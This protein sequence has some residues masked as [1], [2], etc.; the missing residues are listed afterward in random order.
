MAINVLGNGL[1]EA[2]QHADALTV[3]EVE[4][5]MLRRVGGPD[6]QI[7]VTQGNLA[8]TYAI[9]GRY[10]HAS[11]MQREVYSGRLKLL[12]EAHE[13]TLIAA[14]NYASSLIELRRFKEARSLLRKMM[15][16]AR[17][18]LGEGNQCTLNM[19]Q[20][21]AMAL[22][23]DDGATPDDLRE[24]VTRL[25]D[26]ARTAQRVLGRA[27][28]FVANIEAGLREARAAL[29]AREAPPGRSS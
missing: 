8:G 3:G 5:S 21:Y 15:P 13:E 17:R 1:S 14:N 9:L 26:T 20:V 19:R 4:L 2:D 7:L 10:E 29:R 24:A 23:R 16:V 22:Y 28:P 27:H 6:V 12:G 11:R 25:E 18:I